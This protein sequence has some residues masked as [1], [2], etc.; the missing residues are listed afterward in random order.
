MSSFVTGLRVCSASGAVD[1]AF[2][3]TTDLSDPAALRS[4][5]FPV[6]IKSARAVSAAAH[7][8][9]IA[10]QPADVP[11]VLDELKGGPQAQSHR[12]WLG[13]EYVDHGACIFK[14]YVL[15]ANVHVDPRPSTPNAAALP[16]S[17]VFNSQTM[18]K[19]FGDA[20]AQ[21]LHRQRLPLDEAALRQLAAQLSARLQLS[22]FGFDLIVAEA[23]SRAVLVV[24]INYFPSYDGMPELPRLLAEHCLHARGGGS[25]P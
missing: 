20:E 12:H 25:E 22:L 16:R 9:G 13:Q 15:G 23:A 7:V 11:S 21:R 10:L 1:V 17:F 24:D 4:L 19:K 3:R 5:R 18:A 6:I 8:M 2:P 14:C